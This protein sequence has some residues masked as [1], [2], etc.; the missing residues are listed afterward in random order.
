MSDILR[1]T[2]SKGRLHSC[3]L[4][5]LSGCRLSLYPLCSNFPLI[6]AAVFSSTFVLQVL[7]PVSF[8]LGFHTMLIFKVML[9]PANYHLQILKSLL[10]LQA[11]RSQIIFIKLFHYT[12]AS[13]MLTPSSN[14]PYHFS[15]SRLFPSNFD[16]F[17]RT[18]NIFLK[19]HL[20]SK[21]FF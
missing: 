18:S 10:P 11:P 20:S 21:N 4:S 14:I 8:P 17:F 19:F 3:S 7:S 12:I 15:T 1:Y 2:G 9:F 5:F 6:L 13:N 16:P